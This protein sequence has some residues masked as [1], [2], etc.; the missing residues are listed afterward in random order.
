MKMPK[1]LSHGGVVVPMVTPFTSRGELD[2]AAVRRIIDRLA[3]SRLGIFILGTTGEAPSTSPVLRRRFV[4]LAVEYAA[5]RV[6]VY[7]G[8]GD[9]CVSTSIAAGC[10]YL[11]LGVDAVVALL[12]SYYV[13]EAPE[14]QTYFE[15]LAANIRGPVII[16]N[17]PQTTRMSIPVE[18]VEALAR[19]PNIIGLKDSDGTP[20]RIESVARRLSGRP[21]FTLYAGVAAQAGTAL[22][23][24]FTGIVPSSGNLV[25]AWWRDLMDHARADR[26]GEVET[27]QVRLNAVAAVFQTDRTLGQSL[28]ALKLAMHFRGYCNPDVLPPLLPVSKAGRES[29][30]ALLEQLKLP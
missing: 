9:N 13:L 15:H 8:I 21:H 5:G 24:G 3:G 22:R 18:I 1:V 27:L 28:A 11:H 20:G 17:I 29:I 10:E 2:E 19:I 7:A 4:Q 6:L 12:P 23:L 25:Q 16:Y 30:R 14:M 26:W